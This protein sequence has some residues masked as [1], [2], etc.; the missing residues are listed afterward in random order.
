MS[1]APFVGDANHLFNINL[2]FRLFLTYLGCLRSGVDYNDRWGFVVRFPFL[3]HEPPPSTCLLSGDPYC[4]FRFC[5]YSGL[6]LDLDLVVR[7][8]LYLT[9]CIVI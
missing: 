7:C 4:A 9:Q 2:N 5:S 1:R 3:D 6:M 8:S